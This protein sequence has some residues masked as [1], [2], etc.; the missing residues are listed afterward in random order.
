[1]G[2]VAEKYIKT[3]DNKDLQMWIVYP[4][5]FD[6]QRNILRC[7]SATAGRNHRSISSGRTAGISR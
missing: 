5:D 7:S 2:N 6:P 3:K 1:M 4:P